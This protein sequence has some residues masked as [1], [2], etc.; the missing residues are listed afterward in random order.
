M[1]PLRMGDMSV[2][3]AIT[4]P[5]WT[6]FLATE[7]GSYQGNDTDVFPVYRSRATR[8]DSSIPD[9]CDSVAY[10]D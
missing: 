2:S 9:V 6:N 10:T 3:R 8:R 1:Q 4:I 7:A 5:E